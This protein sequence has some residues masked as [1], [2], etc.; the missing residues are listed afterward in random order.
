MSSSRAAA[1][2]M[3]AR[4]MVGRIGIYELM[5][6]DETVGRLIRSSADAQTFWKNSSAVGVD[7]GDW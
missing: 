4:A 3:T 2:A 6:V 5:V 1:I 7:D